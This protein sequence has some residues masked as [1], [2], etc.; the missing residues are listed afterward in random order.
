MAQRVQIVLEDDVDGGVASETV[1]FGLDGVTYE[2]DLND[3]NAGKLRDSLAAW[4]GNAR[5]SAG[6]REVSESCQ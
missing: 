3:D 4:V 2:I 6:R 1:T 5:R